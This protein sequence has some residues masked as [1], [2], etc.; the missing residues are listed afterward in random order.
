MQIEEARFS[1]RKRLTIREFSPGDRP[2]E[3]FLQQ[4]AAILTD[5]ELLAILIGSGTGQ[6]NALE[7][8]RNLLAQAENQLSRLARCSVR[9]LMKTNGIG[10][11]KA[12]AIAAALE[13]GRRRKEEDPSEKPKVVSSQDAYQQFA[14]ELIDLSHE[15]FWLLAVNR[16]HRVI[17]KKRISEGGI[18]GTVVDPRIIFKV[19][20]EELASGI[21]VA[22][23]HPSGNLTASQSDIDL[24]RKLRDAGK[25]LEIPLLDHI[26]VCGNRYLSFAD[27]GLL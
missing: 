26:I 7:I 1:S 14:S 25:F 24:T 27:E 10:E 18:S 5:A 3:K 23:N 19:A 21:I 20:L 22:H 12:L 9:D 17:R 2:R 6:S 13:L 4:G 15:E 8:S 11:A 16:A